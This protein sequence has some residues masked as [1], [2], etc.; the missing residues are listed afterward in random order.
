[1]VAS[2]LNQC[3]NTCAVMGETDLINTF[4]KAR[5]LSKSKSGFG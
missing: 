3:T 4:G 1:M 2:Q 5:S